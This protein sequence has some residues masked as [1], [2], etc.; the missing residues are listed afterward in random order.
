MTGQSH[1]FPLFVLIIASSPVV[2]LWLSGWL[3]DRHYLVERRHV[4]C[5]MTGNQLVDCSRLCFLEPDR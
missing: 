5:R 2:A 4:R 3:A 1:W